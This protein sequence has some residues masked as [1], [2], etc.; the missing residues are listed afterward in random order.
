MARYFNL[1]MQGG[2]NEVEAEQM[3]ECFRNIVL[4]FDSGLTMRCRCWIEQD[5]QGFW[6]TAC[7]P[8]GASY[9][10]CIDSDKHLLT[11]EKQHEEL[12]NLLYRNLH[13]APPFRCAIAGWETQDMIFSGENPP[14]RSFTFADFDIVCDELWNELQRP[15]E[16]SFFK[17]G[18]VVKT[19]LP[20]L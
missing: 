13:D 4:H 7:T 8:L 15:I 2:R 9:G 6:W 16:Y 12:R 1:V 3:A 18:Y 20:Q 10:G 19:T 5:L 14:Y 17:T 11:D